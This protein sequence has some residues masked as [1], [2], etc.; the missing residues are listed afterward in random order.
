MDDHSSSPPKKMGGLDIGKIGGNLSAGSDVVGGNKSDI[1]GDQIRG[2]K[3][4]INIHHDDQEVWPK[5]RFYIGIV[6]ALLAVAALLVVVRSVVP[7][8]PAIIAE[9]IVMEA[10]VPHEER[11][12]KLREVERLYKQLLEKSEAEDPVLREDEAVRKLKSR[13]K[14]M[15]KAGKLEEAEKVYDRALAR[16]LGVIEKTETRGDSPVLRQRR[17][18][19]SR[20]LETMGLLKRTQ[21][22]Y[23]AS[24]QYFRRG[25]EMLS[26]KDGLESRKAVGI[27]FSQA[28]EAYYQLGQYARAEV[29]LK[30]A[31][32]TQESGGNRRGPAYT[33]T[34][35]HLAEV[36]REEGKYGEAEK[37]YEEMLD[38]LEDALEYTEGEEEKK[39]R[40]RMAEALN[41]QGHLFYEQDRSGDERI[42][43]L[44]KESL[45][46]RQELLGD[47]HAEVAESL[48][49]LASLHDRRE[50]YKQARV[51]YER[52]LAV[53]RKILRSDHP[54]ITV[55]LL[56]SAAGVSK[57]RV[58]AHPDIAVTLH[59]LAG[60]Y[61][62]SGDYK[63]AG[64]LYKKALGIKEAI[65]GREHQSVARS[66][67][68]MAELYYVRKKYEKACR[69]Y[70][71]A[72]EIQKKA[73]GKQHP[74][75]AGTLRSLAVLASSQEKFAD[76]V[77]FYEQA[78]AIL[79]KSGHADLPAVRGSLANAL[80]NQAVTLHNES[81]YAEAAPLYERAIG[82]YRKL[83]GRHDA[84]HVLMGDYAALRTALESSGGNADF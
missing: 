8:K 74:S 38:K 76:A 19:A 52:A 9:R 80:H 75:V 58:P 48:N 57:I 20:T 83:P 56:H 60:V 65:L 22:R 41:D 6:A 4:T 69:K 39:A 53:E 68:G 11:E 51:Y 10:K 64:Q 42:E 59:N 55:S 26:P 27:C 82:I 35:K 54:E 50:E 44:F 33:D 63:E 77:S 31:R 73:L 12:G 72:L 5:Y 67:I 30:R 36:Y 29:L 3:T 78:L 46:I 71:E 49:N 62:A 37:L 70:R 84:F 28:G 15:V 2:N 66:Y 18:T 40:L 21:L 17:L 61:R 32:E 79:R 45:D 34:L 81:R 16:E 24:A 14:E 47:E 7:P 25:G 1:V 13:A 23:T 43:P